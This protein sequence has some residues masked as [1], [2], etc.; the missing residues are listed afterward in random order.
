[1]L[2]EG[3]REKKIVSNEQSSFFET[4]TEYFR[5]FCWCCI[6]PSHRAKEEEKVEE[7]QMLTPEDDE[8]AKESGLSNSVCMGVF[9]VWGKWP[10]YFASCD[11]YCALGVI[12]SE[13]LCLNGIG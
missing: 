4:V 11:S 5:Y 7:M 1:M 12:E 10:L 9:V 13:Y 2:I 8:E 6:P 3:T